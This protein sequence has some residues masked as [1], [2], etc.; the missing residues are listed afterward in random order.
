MTGTLIGRCGS[1]GWRR[2]WTTQPSARAAQHDR[3]TEGPPGAYPG[4]VSRM[5]LTILGV[6]LAIWLV[7]MAIGW[8]FAMLKT[9]F[10]IGLIAV[11]VFIVVSLLSK[12]P[13][14]G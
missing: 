14:R 3:P 2:S 9:F 5:I 6:I 13:R 10:M 11:A 12:R 7:L 4:D 8:I 1:A